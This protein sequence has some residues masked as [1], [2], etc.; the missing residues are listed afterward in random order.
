MQ[1]GVEFEALKSFYVSVFS[2]ESNLNVENYCQPKCPPLDLFMLLEKV[3][4]YS[5]LFT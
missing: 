1:V 4:L 5:K 3:Q 2:F